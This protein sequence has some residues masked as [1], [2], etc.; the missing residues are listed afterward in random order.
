MGTLRL[1]QYSE[2]GGVGKTSITT[3]LA[4]TAGDRGMRVLVV[5]LDPRATAS[6]ELGMPIPEAGDPQIFTLN[7]LLYVDSADDEPVNPWDAI[8]DTVHPA[9]E[10][11]PTTIRVLPSERKLAHR[12]TDSAPIEMRLRAGLAA[13]ADEYDLILFDLPPRASGKLV[14]TGLAACADYGGVLI[15]ATLTTDGVDGTAQA[16]RTIK[17]MRQGYSPGLDVAGI[18]RSDVPRD[19]D[20]RAINR[21]MDRQLFDR[22]D[23]ML[24][25]WSDMVLGEPLPT[26]AGDELPIR[27][28]VR[29]YAIREEARYARVPITAAPGREARALVAAYGDILDLLIKRQENREQPH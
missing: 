27:Y 29:H 12:E 28:L 8:L 4:A 11:W 22:V 23:T 19:P 20:L 16:L 24:G 25:A 17:Q 10:S 21:E 18:V 3:G 7:D 15:P 5:D 6:I 14:T 1:A 13:V 9:G 2:K 26:S